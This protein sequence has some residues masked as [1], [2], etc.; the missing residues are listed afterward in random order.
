MI[1]MIFYIASATDTRYIQKLYFLH[2]YSLFRILLLRIVIV[3]ALIYSIIY[4]YVA[5]FPDSGDVHKSP[6]IFANSSIDVVAYLVRRESLLNLSVSMHYL[7]RSFND[8]LTLPV[9]VFYERHDLSEVEARRVL[10]S[11]IGGRR[12]ALV[13]FHAVAFEFPPGYDPLFAHPV[14]LHEAARFPGYHHMCDF[15]LRGLFLHPRLSR[16]RYVMRL[17]ADSYLVGRLEY[18]LFARLARLGV[19]YAWRAHRGDVL[20]PPSHALP[21]PLRAREPS[22]RHC[23]ARVALVGEFRAPAC[24]LPA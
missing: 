21:A 9:L 1:V 17:D 20:H 12:L 24:C 11:A 7:F 3:I 15:W 13:E 4:I 19:S 10:R 16:V 2:L 23:G 5:V 6:E 22:R 14:G 18:D 8:R